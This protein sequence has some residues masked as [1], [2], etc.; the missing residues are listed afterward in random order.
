[1]NMKHVMVIFQTLAAMGAGTNILL[2]HI[3]IK[4][5]E[6]K[7]M[8]AELLGTQNAP[9]MQ[10]GFMAIIC[11]CGTLATTMYNLEKSGNNK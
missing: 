6:S 10:I 1:M 11:I 9:L 5:P 2:A 4:F 8:I 3:M 7:E